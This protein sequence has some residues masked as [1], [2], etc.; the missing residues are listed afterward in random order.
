MGGDADIFVEELGR[1]IGRE[2][3]FRSRSQNRQAAS[4]R[5][6]DKPA[7]RAQGHTKSS[8][9][10]EARV[11]RNGGEGEVRRDIWQVLTQLWLCEV[12]SSRCSMSTFIFT[13]KVT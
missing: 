13:F 1:L 6:H 4:K 11:T 5:Q 8:W 10:I 12:Q 2:A 7:Q 3:C 9:G